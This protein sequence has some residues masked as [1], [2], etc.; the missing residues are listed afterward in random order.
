VKVQKLA[1]LVLLAIAALL[2]VWAFVHLPWQDSGFAIDW[3]QIWQ[4]TQGLRADYANT[5]LRTPPW[6]LPILWLFTSFPLSASWALAACATLAVLVLSVPHIA[7][8]RMWLLGVLLLASSYPALR[9]MVD[10]NLEA[11]V[12]GGVLLLLW[13]ARRQHPLGLAIGLLLAAAKVQETWLLLIVLSHILI[14]TWPK[15]SLLQTL[16][17]AAA[18]AIPFL[19]WRGG[20]WLFAI[21]HFPWPGTAIDSSLQAAIGRLGLPTFLYWAIWLVVLVA[22]MIGISRRS[23][24]LGRVEAGLL[25]TAG[26]LLAPYAASNSVLTPLA[27]GVTPFFQEHRRLGLGLLLFYF[28]PYLALARPDLRAAYESTYWTAV[29]LLTWLFSLFC[30]DSSRLLGNQR[31]HRPLRVQN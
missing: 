21:M 23:W 14:R 20:D 8:K 2:F 18:L 10:G 9:Q 24:M 1:A 29:L 5:E 25:V 11:L 6:A 3:K 17:Y 15:R 31:N 26:L 19:I 13:A 28:L 16:A 7:G 30:R 27:I 4:A 22:T 12:I